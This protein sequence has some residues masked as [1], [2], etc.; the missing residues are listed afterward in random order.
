MKN[1]WNILPTADQKKV[2]SLAVELNKLNPTLAN[3]LIQRGVDTFEKAKDYFRPSLNDLHD[4]FLMKDMQ[5]AVERLQ[6]A[7]EKGEKVLIYGDYDVDGN[8]SV[9]LVYSYLKQFYSNIEYYI[10]DRYTEGYGISYQGID[11][12]KENDF[13]LIIALDCGI[14]AIEKIAYA[15]EKNIDFIICDHH[16]PGESTPEAVAVLDTKRKDCQYPFKELSGCGVGF[17]LMQAYATSENL[18]LESLLDKIDFL[19]VSICADIV[20]MVGENRI[21]TYYGMKKLN[22]Q[23]QKAFSAMLNTA[24]VNKK[25]LTVTDVVFT[26]AP[27]IN[28]AGRMKSGNEAVA[29]LISKDIVS[30]EKSSTQINIYNNDRKLHDSSITQEALAIIA[31]DKQLL[32]QKT[33]VLYNEGWHKGVIGIVASRCIESY[34]RPTIILTKSKGMAAGSA[35]SVKGFNIYNALEACEELLEQFGGHKYAAG[36]T[37]PIENIPAFQ[38][39]FE[40]VVADSIPQALLSPEIEIDANLSLDEVDNKFYNIL[41]QFAPVGPGNMKPVFISRGLK[42]KGDGSL[43]KEKHLK[44]NIYDPK[45]AKNYY[46]A[47]GFNLYEKYHLVKSGEPFDMVYTIELNEW[48][49]RSTIQ[50]NIK[51]I[52]ASDSIEA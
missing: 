38:K 36:M 34:Y 18:E 43:L 37:L 24:G 45:T 46:P 9:A 50:L 8:T 2:Q 21:L 39:R 47:I 35:R 32:Q 19:A 40:E 31:E 4:P 20:P 28:A 49:G 48:N 16:T 42:E 23:P 27:R 22:S 5:K 30:A 29:L 6:A 14:K 1:R 51:D 25:E 52:R 7:I 10:P 13:S 15:N 12:A 17:K 41:R 44:L 26:I 11:F 33:T 3:I